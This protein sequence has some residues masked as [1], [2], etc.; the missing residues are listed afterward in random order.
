MKWGAD[1]D[2]N[3][4]CLC[5]WLFEGAHIGRKRMWNPR[6]IVD[7][8]LWRNLNQRSCRFIWLLQ[9]HSFKGRTLWSRVLHETKS[10]NLLKCSC[11]ISI[12]ITSICIFFIALFSS[13]PFYFILH[14]SPTEINPVQ[15]IF[16]FG[17]LL[18]VKNVLL[19]PSP[20]FVY[21]VHILFYSMFRFVMAIIR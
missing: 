9:F 5:S 15:G 6:K 2:K 21:E 12:V 10:R 1:S 13:F 16:Y 18:G 4:Q 11:S 17:V 7:R 3:I 19:D 8:L 14:S 20:Q